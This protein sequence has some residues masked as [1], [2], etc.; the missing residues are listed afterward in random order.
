MLITTGCMGPCSHGAVVGVG[1]RVPTKPGDP[2]VV[3]G[4]Q[5]LGGM[6]RP[7]RAE[8]LTAWFEEGGPGCVP[9]PMPVL[10]E[11]SLGN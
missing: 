10:T 2:L 9:L 11:A 1:H 3:L 7:I 6:E 8:A 4:V 5:L